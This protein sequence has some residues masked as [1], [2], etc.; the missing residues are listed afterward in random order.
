MGIKL[1]LRKIPAVVAKGSKSTWIQDPTFLPY[2]RRRCTANLIHANLWPHFN[3]IQ[4]FNH[5]PYKVQIWKAKTKTLKQ[6]QENPVDP[7]QFF[8]KTEKETFI[9]NPNRFII[10]PFPDKSHFIQIKKLLRLRVN[11]SK[12]IQNPFLELLIELTSYLGVHTKVKKTT[13][14]GP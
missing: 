2:R 14:G 4:S 11:N 10:N 3:K 13:G 8:Q 12:G 1:E 6:D 5:K 9:N 7:D